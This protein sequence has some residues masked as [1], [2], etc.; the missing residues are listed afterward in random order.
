MTDRYNALTV[1]LAT[2]VRDDDAEA[3]LSAIRQFRG[4]VSVTGNVTDPA[5]HVAQQRARHELETKLLEA[6]RG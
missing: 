1:V 4:V 2:D 3:L 5:S 6:L